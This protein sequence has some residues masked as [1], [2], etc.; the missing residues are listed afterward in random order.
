MFYK[1]YNSRYPKPNEGAPAPSYLRCYKCQGQG[2]YP[3]QCPMPKVQEKPSA[4]PPTGIPRSSF[5]PAQ[6]TDKGA[7]LTAEGQ[8]VVTHIDA[9]LISSVYRRT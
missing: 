3:N 8:Y 7:K 9:G 5:K 6:A 2:H 1:W 4:R